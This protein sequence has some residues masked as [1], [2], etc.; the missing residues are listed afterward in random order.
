MYVLYIWKEAHCFSEL[1]IGRPAAALKATD[2]TKSNIRMK[3]QNFLLQIFLFVQTV[4]SSYSE[5]HDSHNFSLF[6]AAD[7][8]HHSDRCQNHGLRQ[9]SGII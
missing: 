6:Y 2:D 3:K 4:L 5:K 7:M 1:P 8:D 9:V